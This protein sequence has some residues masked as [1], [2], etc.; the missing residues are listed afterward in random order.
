MRDAKQCPTEGYEFKADLGNT[1]AGDGKKFKGAGYLQVTGR[2][3]FKR[4]SEWVKDPKVMEGAF[5]V[6]ANYPGT[7]AAFWWTENKMNAMIDGE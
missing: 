1:V 7:I 5:Y 6:G 2:S 3:W 4:F